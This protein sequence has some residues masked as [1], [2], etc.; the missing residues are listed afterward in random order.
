MYNIYKYIYFVY[1]KVNSII[2]IE[3]KTFFFFLQSTVSLGQYL[4]EPLAQVLCAVGGEQR[5]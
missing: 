2:Y 4:Q 1:R 3:R 5:L